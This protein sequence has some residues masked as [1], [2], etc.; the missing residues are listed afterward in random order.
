MKKTKVKTEEARETAGDFLRTKRE[1]LGASVQTLAESMGIPMRTLHRW[2]GGHSKILAKHFDV[3]KKG[4]QLTEE[5][6]T[7]FEGLLNLERARKPHGLELESLSDSLS[8]QR[9]FFRYSLLPKEER[10]HLLR[11]MNAYESTFETE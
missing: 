5:E 2:E 10:D 6:T 8:M 7:V 3:L 4:Y 11:M 9:L 1:D